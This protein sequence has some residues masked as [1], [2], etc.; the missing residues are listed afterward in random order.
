MTTGTSPDGTL[1]D[2]AHTTIRKT[3]FFKASRETVWAF[4]TEQDKL[5]QWFHRPEK[6]LADGEDYV[7]IRTD[8][9]G[10]QSPIIWG[11][12]I[13]MEAPRKL[14]TSFIITPFG[15]AETTVTWILEEA[16]G[17]TRLSLTHEGVAEAAGVETLRMLMSLDRGWDEHLET[18]RKAAAI[19]AAIASGQ[20]MA[21]T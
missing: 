19:E 2:S 8:D 20:E 1:P 17:G 21:G 11:R 5:A 10:A 4:L 6:D 13:S 9:A 16:A 7:L 12:V 3:A 14:V 18:M 15:G